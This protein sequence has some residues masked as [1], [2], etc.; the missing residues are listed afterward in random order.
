MSTLH[1]ISHTHWDREWYRTY[2]QFRLQLVHL[3][4][5][6]L[7]ILDH[8]PYFLHFM[9]DGQT[10]VL[11]DYFAI[12]PEREAELTAYMHNGRILTGPWYILPDEFLVS[13]EA[14]IRN[15]LQGERDSVKYGSKMNIG[16]L[17][18]T[19]GHIGQMPQ[20]LSGFGLETAALWR[21]IDGQPCELWWQAPDGTRIFLI[22]LHESYSNGAGLPTTDP[23]AFSQTLSKLDQNLQPFSASQHRLIMFGTDHMEPA[24]ET[25]SL[26]RYADEELG[27]TQVIHSTLPDYLESLKTDLDFNQLPVVEGELRSSKRA[28]LLPGVLST[29]MWIKQR[30]HTCEI[31]LE[32]WAE[33]FSVWASLLEGDSFQERPNHNAEERLSHP[34]A[35]LQQAWRLLMENHPHDSICGCS[36]D[37][38]HDE[39]RPRFDQ[40]EQVGEEITSQSLAAIQSS[41]NTA[42]IPA[43]VVEAQAAIL[44]FNPSSFPL[45]GISNTRIQLPD[46]MD[47]FDLLDR[48]GNSLPYSLGGRDNASLFNM[49]LPADEFKNLIGMVHNGKIANLTMTSMT[50]ERQADTVELHFIM[51]E[52]PN[53][54]VNAWKDWMEIVQAYL[55]DETVKYFHITAQAAD[56][57]ELS[58]V[59][60]DV[61]GC[62]LATFWL[63]KKT[64]VSPSPMKLGRL[65]KFLLPVAYR[66]SSVKVFQRLAEM[67]QPDIMKPPYTIE[68]EYFLIEASSKDGSLNLEVKQDGLHYRNLNRFMDGADCGDEYNYSPPRNDKFFTVQKI[69]KVRLEKTAFLQKLILDLEMTL[70]KSLTAERDGRS[71]ETVV[72]PITTQVSLINGIPRIDIQTKIDNAA[73]DHRLRVHF[74]A[75][76]KVMEAWYDGHFEIIRRAIGVP[77]WDDTWAEEPRPEKPQRAFTALYGE[78]SGL[79]IANRG[80]PEVEALQNPNGYSEIALTLMRCVGWLSRDDFSTRHSHAGPYLPTP[81]AQLQNTSIFD[82]SIIPY[83]S[84]PEAFQAACRQAYAFTAPLRSTI[85]QIHAGTIPPDSALIQVDPPS[86]IISAI[87]TTENQRYQGKSTWIVR[88]YNP[89]DKTIQVKLKPWRRANRADLVNLAEIPQKEIEL[90]EDGSAVLSVNPQQIVSIQFT[91]QMDSP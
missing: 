38:V 80:L 61:P 37:Q 24:P 36:I 39:M 68:N 42:H 75:P 76:F 87:K 1:I 72:V 89:Q 73:Q 51:L 74:P 79:M 6:L 82:Y 70:P 34:A 59:A 67:R 53:I 91:H 78:R 5:N 43:K 4:D 11:Q 29:R 65:G 10:I 13:P 35:L 47:D 41:V 28:H 26:I 25:S 58:F 8:D 69:K 62:G 48:N 2:Q 49:T 16:Y 45:S 81:G 7:A 3:I 12:R 57:F 66:L 19:F 15:L 23:K 77:P 33:P 90:S 83:S 30:N 32:K 46:G 64:S 18:D 86:F 21:G 55:S 71:S 56:S 50:V 60:K 85:A 31:L 63:R 52:G 17:P 88:G 20:I 27:D 9:L 40:V 54:E 84:N 22:N 44:V 14:H